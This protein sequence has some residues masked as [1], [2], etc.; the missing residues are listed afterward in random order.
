METLTP[1]RAARI[2]L[3]TAIAGALLF[4]GDDRREIKRTDEKEVKVHLESVIGTVNVN[5]GESN[6]ILMMQME[7]ER[8]SSDPVAV[9]YI[10]RRNIGTLNLNWNPEHKNSWNF[11]EGDRWDIQLTDAVP[12]SI[13]ANFGVGKANFDMTGL[14]VKAL[15]IGTGASSTTV[16]FGT[17]NKSVIDHFQIECGVSKFVGRKLGNANFQD[18]TFDGGIGAYELDFGG[19]IDREVDAHIK[20]GLGTV[21]VTIPSDIGA[22]I[23]YD[24]GWLSNFSIDSHFSRQHGDTYTTS[25]YEQSKGKI[26]VYVESGLGSVKIRCRD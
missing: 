1:Y 22:K 6:K 20:I 14:N 25:N 15:K 3:L 8:Q 18:M 17:F 9:D 4:A 19:A 16:T 13:A 11:R 5:K 2:L 12:L 21:T 24:E 7:T 26:N 23:V 10:V